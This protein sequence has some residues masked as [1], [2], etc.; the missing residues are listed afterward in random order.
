MSKVQSILSNSLIKR[1]I[2]ISRERNE[3]APRLNEKIEDGI[4]IANEAQSSK[5]KGKRRG[6]R[7]GKAQRVIR[8]K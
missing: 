8:R 3:E 6:K 5:S 4:R 7:K 2:K 1:G